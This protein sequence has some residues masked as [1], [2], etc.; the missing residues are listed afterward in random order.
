MISDKCAW[1][2]KYNLQ[3]SNYFKIFEIHSHLQL[4]HHDEHF[5]YTWICIL[6]LIS[7][8]LHKQHSVMLITASFCYWFYLVF[9]SIRRQSP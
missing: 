1:D 7:I 4:I 9:L 5:T 6:L 8:I 2:K 3:N